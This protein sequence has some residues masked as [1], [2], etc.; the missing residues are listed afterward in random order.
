MEQEYINNELLLLIYGECDV[1]RRL[2]LEHA[3]SEDARLSAEMDSML[4]SLESLPKV[5]YSPKR[6][7]VENILGYAMA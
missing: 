6:K 4:D 5:L 7:S 1:F 2:E 3:L